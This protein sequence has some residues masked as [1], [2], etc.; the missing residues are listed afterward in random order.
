MANTEANLGLVQAIKISTTQPTNTAQIWFDD[1]VGQK[2]HKVYDTVSGTWI[3]LAPNAG[4]GFGVY[5]VAINNSVSINV[6]QSTHQIVEI[7]NIQILKYLPLPDDYF[8]FVDLP[9]ENITYKIMPN[10]DV[11]IDN[12]NQVLLQVK[13]SGRK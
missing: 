5:T 7:S 8:E 1:N 9:T 13:I 10:F 2:V 4:Q 11:E 3:L 12:P 6:F